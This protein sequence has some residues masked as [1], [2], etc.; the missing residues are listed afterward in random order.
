[1]PNIIQSSKGSEEIVGKDDSQSSTSMFFLIRF[2]GHFVQVPNADK[3]IN[4]DML[5]KSLECL[6]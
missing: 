2:W 3:I 6:C 5:K 1:L 4:E